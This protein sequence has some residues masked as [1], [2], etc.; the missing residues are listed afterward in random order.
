MIA[1]LLFPAFSP[2]FAYG[3]QNF[4]AGQRRG[5]PIAM[6]LNLGVLRLRSSACGSVCAN[7][8]WLPLATSSK[9]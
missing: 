2:L 3:S 9:K 1:A 6:L 7:M 8:Q 4:I 5:F